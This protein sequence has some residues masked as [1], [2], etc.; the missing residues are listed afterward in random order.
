MLENET[1][2]IV[3]V[4]GANGFVGRSVVDAL[5]KSSFGVRAAIRRSGRAS[6]LAGHEVAVGDIG[7]DTCW[8]DA[9]VGV[10]MLVHLAARVHVM[11]DTVT[12]PLAE[13]RKVNV[14]GTE[15]LARD[16]RPSPANPISVRLV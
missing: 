8:E 11:H 13:F 4:T 9:L 3:L 10:S 7:P 15:R 5:S 6:S 1:N 12:D 14:L 16:I 2:P